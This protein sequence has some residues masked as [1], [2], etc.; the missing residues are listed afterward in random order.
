VSVR[1]DA[2]RAILE[3]ERGKF[4][5]EAVRPNFSGWN[6]QM[7]YHFPDIGEHWLLRFVD[8][9]AQAPEQLATP[10]A[11]PDIH[12]EMATWTLKAMSA[13]ELSGEK[14]YLT[15]QLRIKAS[16]GDMLKLQSLNKK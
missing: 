11:K 3:T 1:G 5:L 13:G 8:G 14:A 6:K 12:Y 10:I 16:F 7:Q 9:E 2:L 4:G 15:R